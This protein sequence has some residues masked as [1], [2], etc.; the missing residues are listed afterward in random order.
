M[1]KFFFDILLNIKKIFGNI[2]KLAIEFKNI[3]NNF[4]KIEYSYSIYLIGK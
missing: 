4:S 3:I 1:K 2:A